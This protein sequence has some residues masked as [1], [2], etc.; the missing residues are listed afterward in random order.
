MKVVHIVEAFWGGVFDFLVNLTKGLEDVEHIIVYSTREETPKDFQKYFWPNVKFIHW[1]NAQRE[2][3]PLQDLKAFLSLRGILKNL[4]ADVYHLHSSKAG[5]LWRLV[6]WLK[7][8][9]KKVIYSTHWLAFKDTGFSTRQQKFIQFLERLAAKIFGGKVVGN[10]E[11]ELSQLKKL[12]I[13]AES[14]PNAVNCEVPDKISSNNKDKLKVWM[15]ARAVKVKGVDLFLQIYDLLKNNPKLEFVWIWW[16]QQEEQLKR[17][18]VNVTWWL[19]ADKALDHLQDIDIFLFTSA[20]DAVP[21]A[22]LQAM[23][24]G[25]PAV[26]LD[27]P[28]AREAIQHGK[29][30]FLFTSP[31]EA[32]RLIEQLAADPQLRKKIG[33]QAAELVKNKYDYHSWLNAYRRLYQSFS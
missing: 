14:I 30:G 11:F 3:K 18:W 5:F 9:S 12:G 29:T 7:G 8:K 25:K 28:F 21:L 4:D 19:P 17:A 22:L 23:C 6:L 10:S 31:S 1:P 13:K 24:L 16:G 27:T 15:M 2:I 32:A 26:A 33:T 20:N